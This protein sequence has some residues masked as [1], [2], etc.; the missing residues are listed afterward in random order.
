M[1][2]ETFLRRFR[3][4]R[5]SAILRT[6]DSE[7]AALAMEAADELC[8][9]RLVL[10]HEGG[11][12]EVYVPF[13]GHAVLQELSGS[14]ITAEDPLAETL[15]KRQPGPRFQRFCSEWVDDLSRLLL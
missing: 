8:D 11:Y 1:K 9:G 3:D 13:C 7:K 10:V 12:S 2:A 5:A 14:T 4:E 15:E 6:D